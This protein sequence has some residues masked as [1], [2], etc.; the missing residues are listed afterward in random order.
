MIVI[1]GSLYLALAYCLNIVGLRHQ[2]FLVLK[3]YR[4]A[5]S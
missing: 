3:R 1:G 5:V 4:P 2:L